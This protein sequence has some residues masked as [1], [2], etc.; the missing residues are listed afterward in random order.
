MVD[1][2]QSPEG[3]AAEGVA[4]ISLSSAFIGLVAADLI[5]PWSTFVHTGH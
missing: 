5:Q 3:A 4:D 1:W 2:L